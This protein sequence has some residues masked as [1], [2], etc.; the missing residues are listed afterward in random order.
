MT[1]LWWAE[2]TAGEI[3]WCHFLDRIDPR[4]KPALVLAVFDDDD[5]QF[6]C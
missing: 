6:H 4:P 3:V 2:P 1:S 5:P